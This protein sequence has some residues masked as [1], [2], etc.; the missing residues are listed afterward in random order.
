MMLTPESKRC[1]PKALQKWLYSSVLWQWDDNDWCRLDGERTE[2]VKKAWCVL[3]V[4]GVP[5]RRLA[6]GSGF[7]RAYG[8]VAVRVVV[9]RAQRVR[10]EDP[11]ELL[12]GAVDCTTTP[13]E[14]ILQ[15]EKV[16]WGYRK[17]KKNANFFLFLL[18]LRHILSSYLA[19]IWHFNKGLISFPV[20]VQL[21][22]EISGIRWPSHVKNPQSQETRNQSGVMCGVQKHLPVRESISRVK[23]LKTN[24]SYVWNNAR[25]TCLALMRCPVVSPRCCPPTCAREVPQT[26]ASSLCHRQQEKGSLWSWMHKW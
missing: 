3:A 9:F 19:Y 4:S 26:A 18:I 7:G 5:M 16:T 22:S 14:L 6:Q 1:N 8:S 20:L 24:H 12:Q 2:D 13:N 11:F 21:H 17:K 23:H 10:G 15:K 25:P